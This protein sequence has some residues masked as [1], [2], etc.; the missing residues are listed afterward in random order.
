MYVLSEFVRIL[1][2]KHV[3]RFFR[4]GY[5]P[6]PGKFPTIN[7]LLLVYSSVQGPPPAFSGTMGSEKYVF[8]KK[9]FKNYE[10]NIT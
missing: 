2:E 3:F 1:S 7:S 6:E 4:P 8:R 10:K 9:I 5:I